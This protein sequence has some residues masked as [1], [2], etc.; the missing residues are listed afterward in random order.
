VKQK[1]ERKARDE[2][3]DAAFAQYLTEERKKDIEKQRE[4]DNA[5][6]ARSKLAFISYSNIYVILNCGII[7]T[8]I[9][10]NV[11]NFENVRN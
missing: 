10:K 9:V 5:R 1:A 8:V 2:A 7:H 6:R 3:I 4:D 11:E